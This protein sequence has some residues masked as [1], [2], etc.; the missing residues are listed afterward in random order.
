MS[1]GAGRSGKSVDLDQETGRQRIS[2]GFSKEETISDRI[3][4]SF[5]ITMGAKI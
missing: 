1:N 4:R 5:I 3:K 2:T